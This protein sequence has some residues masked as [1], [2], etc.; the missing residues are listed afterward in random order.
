M[1]DNIIKRDCP[2]VTVSVLTYNSSKYI[3]E[4]LESIRVQTYSNIELIVSDDKSTDNTVQICEDWIAKNKDRFASVQVIVADHNTGQSGNYNRAFR[5]ATGEWIKEID[6][7]DRLLPN[8]LTDLVDFV[9][10]NP[11]AKYVFGKM[12]GFGASKIKVDSI[13]S[14]FDYSF[15]QLEPKQQLDRLL[16]VGNC[17]PSPT[18]FYNRKYINEIDFENDERIPY[19]EDYPKWIN[20]LKKGVK[21]YFLDKEVASYRVDGGVS[22]SFPSEKYFNTCSLFKVLYCYSEW[23]NRDPENGINKIIEDRNKMYGMMK[24]YHE[25]AL[26][27]QKSLSYRIGHFI[28]TPFRFFKRLFSFL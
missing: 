4:T 1:S 20:L 3:L 10:D 16:Y 19:L 17:V 26:G 14:H 5:A 12:N 13:L 2:V 9:N 8:C 28:L 6:G 22:T 25:E 15:F 21:F 11:N 24:F 7:D 23:I 27:Y 18:S